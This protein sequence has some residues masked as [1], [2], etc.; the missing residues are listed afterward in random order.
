MSEGIA[1]RSMDKTALDAGLV[2]AHGHLRSILADF[3]GERW[4]VPFLPGIN[5]PMWEF[6][7]V[8]WVCEW[9]ILRE[10]GHDGN[11]GT[12]ARHSSE[13]APADRWFD[14]GKA[15]HATRWDLD[16]PSAAGV[17]A[18]ADSVLERVRARLVQEPDGDAAL[19][20][21]RLALFH[22]DM[23]GEALTYMRQTLDLPP[24]R[25]YKVATVDDTGDAQLDGAKFAMG[26][27]GGGFAFDN[28]LIAHEVEVKPFAI[29][30]NCVSNRQYAEFVAAGG[31]AEAKYWSEEGRVWLRNAPTH[32]VRWRR[33]GDAWE[34]SWFG[35][36]RALPYASPLI[37]VNA[38]EAEA[39]C[40]WAGRRL[41]TE[42][43][44]EFA[45][46]NGAIRW[47]HSVWEWL[48]D[49]FLPFAGFEPGRYVE[50]S[51][52]WF[53]SHRSLRG[54]SF[55]TRSR[56]HHP[57]YRNFYLPQRTD[58]FAGFRTCAL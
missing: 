4:R 19:Y 27:S 15:A 2:D 40:A 16:L 21:Y 35:S 23:H 24:A 20:P 18:Y 43:E 54:G 38:Y 26:V 12:V 13:L 33:V 37:H 22:S 47:G 11:G 41:P 51:K 45:A 53:H 48:A 39:Y 50:Y 30:R 34:E 9:W 55:A 32:P 49:D 8:A 31:Y 14:S 44:W 29:A 56:M 36:W 10:A 25:N 17:Y 28:E 58:I 46:M 5:P 57:R 7:H 52:P 42:A 3:D 1:A 6:G